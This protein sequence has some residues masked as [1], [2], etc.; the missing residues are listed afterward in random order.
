VLVRVNQA[1]FGTLRA[2]ALVKVAQETRAARQL[3]VDQVTALYNN[4]LRSEVDVAFVA[5]ELANAKLLVL[6]ADD[7]VQQ[8]FAEL[9]RDLGSQDGA[10]YQLADEPMPPS[11][12]L[13]VEDLVQQALSARPELASL[14][15]NRDAA[16][17]FERAERDLALPTASFIGVGGFMPYIAQ[18]SLPRVTP[19]EYEGV[20]VNV[21]IPIMNGGLFKARREE[22]HYRA[23]ES[24]QRLRDEA[25]A[26]A[27]DVRTAWASASTAYQRLDVTAE[28]MRQASLAKDLA[29]GRYDLGLSTIVELTQALLNV[30][31]ADIQNM[32]AKY[33]YQAQ[34]ATLQYSIGALR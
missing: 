4:K 5:V 14:K 24:D 12:P 15:L 9:T 18:L 26:I 27:R 1:Y 19:A 13:K 16:Y 25:E 8:A 2:Q 23:M 31:S 30:T 11:P 21:E 32:N 34:F 7:Q 6:Q 29:Q 20:A 33:D 28:L 3:L 22:A 10:T 17:K